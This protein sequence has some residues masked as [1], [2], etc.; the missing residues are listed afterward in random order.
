MFPVFPGWSYQQNRLFPS[1]VIAFEAGTTSVAVVCKDFCLQLGAS[2]WFYA[3]FI[4]HRQQRAPTS[5]TALFLQQIL[6]LL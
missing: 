6:V 5:Y 2:H 4:P 3:H 1:G